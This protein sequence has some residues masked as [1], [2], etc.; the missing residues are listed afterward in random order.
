MSIPCTLYL[1]PSGQASKSQL[2]EGL[3]G[4]LAEG[5]EGQLAEGLEVVKFAVKFVVKFAVKFAV[6]FVVKFV[7]KGKSNLWSVVSQGIAHREFVLWFCSEIG[8]KRLAFFT[9]RNVVS[10]QIPRALERGQK[11]QGGGFERGVKSSGFDGFE[12]GSNAADLTAS[13][14]GQM[15]RI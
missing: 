3:E 9:V 8:R 4:Q 2:A 7:V 10:L 6:K 14:E 12:R 13:K 11:G 1:D 5:S 15:Q